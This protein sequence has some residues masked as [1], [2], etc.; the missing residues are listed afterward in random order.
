LFFEKPT[1]PTAD[2]SAITEPVLTAAILL[3]LFIAKFTISAFALPIVNFSEAYYGFLVP[4][5]L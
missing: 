1:L 4:Q 2:S 5:L 3:F